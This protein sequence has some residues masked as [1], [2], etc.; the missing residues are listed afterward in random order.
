MN[1]QQPMRNLAIARGL[2]QE[3]AVAKAWFVL[4]AHDDNPD[5]RKHWQSWAKFL[6]D[7]ATAPLLP[8]STVVQAAQEDGNDSWAAW[9]RERYRLG[10][11][12]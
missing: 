2:E 7:P 8:A 1:A 3:G 10:G 9:M 6:P 11:S 5:V 12:R 4:C